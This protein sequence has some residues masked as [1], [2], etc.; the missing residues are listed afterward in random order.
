MTTDALP[1][2]GI[3]L[4]APVPRGR[5]LGGDIMTA[6]EEAS[7][8]GF[9]TDSENIAIGWLVSR[10][11][12][13]K[14]TCPYGCGSAIR[15]LDHDNKSV[16]WTCGSYRWCSEVSQSS[17]CKML[18][19]TKERDE[20]LAALKSTAADNERLKAGEDAVRKI[21][22]EIFAQAIMGLADAAIIRQSEYTAENVLAAVAQLSAEC[23]LLRKQQAKP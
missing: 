6:I 20:A 10:I 3:P 16:V 14:A 21:L 19:L 17:A 22:V 5:F 23:R 15:E 2:A 13:S 8:L 9:V 11:E 7:K 12:S 18:V 4:L 1:R